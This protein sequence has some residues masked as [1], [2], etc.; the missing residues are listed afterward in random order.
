MFLDAKSRY[1]FNSC[2]AGLMLSCYISVN[3][4]E[5]KTAAPNGAP[6]AS[7]ITGGANTPTKV[8]SLGVAKNKTV[9]KYHAVEKVDLGNFNLFNGNT[10]QA[11]EAYKA[12]LELDPNRWEAHYGLSSCY[13]RKARFAEAIDECEDVLAQ[14]PNDKN[15][16]LL[17]G[18]LFKIQGRLPEA[19]ATFERLEKLG[20]K[21]DALH[22]A[23]GLALAQSNRLDEASTHLNLVLAKEGKTINS[24][25]HL[26]EAVILFKQNKS[27]DALVHLDKAIRGRGGKYAQARDFK[28][29]ILVHMGKIEEAKAEYLTE[30]KNEDPP[31]SCFQALGN[32]YLQEQNFPAAIVI[33]DKGRKWYPRDE[34]IALG[35]AVTLERLKRL[36][37]AILAFKKALPLVKEKNKMVQWQKHLLELQT[38]TSPRKISDG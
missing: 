26:G 5:H 25:A 23:L 13:T 29:D 33:F 38:I 22:T 24:D 11:I 15:T 16:L 27:E 10:R 34:D 20:V 18:N 21:T 37:E 7:A 30:I 31:A 28:A 4:Q 35:R 1:L 36:P 32:L 14:K 6:T 9:A 8:F 3:G 19:V 2:L 12:A 17:L